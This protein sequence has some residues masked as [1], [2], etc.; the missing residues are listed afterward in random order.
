MR[1]APEPSLPSPPT[2]SGTAVLLCNLG[3]PSAATAAAVRPYL[4]EFLSDPRVVEIPRLAW[5][6]ILHGLILPLRPKASA[7]KYQQVWNQGGASGSPLLH[8]TQQQARLLQA[9]LN[10][11]GGQAIPVAHAMRYGQPGIA[12]QLDALKA[13]GAQ[14]ILIVPLY[15]QY[16]G[17]TTAS[18]CDGVYAWARTQR[19]IPELRFVQ[20]YHQHP[21]Y[22][23]ALAASVQA[24]WQ[25]RG[26]AEKLILSFHGVPR[27]TRDLGD[28]YIDECHQTAQLL[29]QALQ[30]APEA[31]QVTFQS[32]FGKAQW[33]EPYT[34]PTVEALARSGTRSLDV[35]C[36][37]F[38][39]DCIETL[40]EI[41]LE[42]RQAFLAAGGQDY[43]FIPCL[44]D[45]ADWIAALRDLCAQHLQGW[46]TSLDL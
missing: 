36:P 35:L 14:R 10:P 3:T 28:P 31:Y 12:S 27:R 7:A 34:Q 37:G 43:R 2:T 1:F 45:R 6:P 8:W 30:L 46:P 39:S 40:E 44:N 18:V 33:V 29:A 19:H 38:A 23:A 5:W 41:D 4:A 9:A 16:S 21:G 20:R 42:V 24:H 26:R 17:T 11:D 22:I 13:Q 32:R 25:A 15:P